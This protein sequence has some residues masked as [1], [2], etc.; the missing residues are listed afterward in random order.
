MHYPFWDTSVSYGLMMA[1]IAIVHVFISHFAIGGGFYLVITETIA[2]NRNDTHQLDYLKKISKF[3]ILTTLVMG[4]LTGVAI[5]TIIGLI[6][7]S[8]TEVLIHNF[9][10]GW[11]IEW[12]F[13]VVEIAA[14]LMYYYGWER[15]TAKA[16]I[17]LGWIYFIF[18]WLS[19]VVINGIVAFMLTP[20]QWLETGDFWDGFF[21]PTYWPSLVFRTGI[22][23]LLAGL[24]TM[25]YVSKI[26]DANSKKITVRYNAIWGLIGAAIVL[27]SLVWYEAAIPATFMETAREIMSFPFEIMG[28]IN[29]F[30]W[31]IV[32]L[33]LI[34]GFLIPKRMH[35]TVAVLLMALGFCYFGSFEWWRESLRKPFVIVDYMYGNRVA[36][37]TVSETAAAGFLPGVEYRT[38]DDGADLFRQQCRTCHTISGYKAL[39]PHYD[40]TDIDFIAGTIIGQHTMIGNMPPFSGTPQEA[41]LIAAHLYQFTDH[42]HISEIYNLSGQS[43]GEKV[44][45]IRCGKCHVIGGYSDKTESLVNLDDGE[46]ND[47]L[48]IIGELTDEMPAFTGDSTERAAL[49]EYFK[50]LSKGDPHAPGI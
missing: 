22:S 44:Y 43:L 50:T 48:D 28:M 30:L 20:G 46:Y 18:A 37:N 6:N 38:G 45:E 47:L 24:F 4:A 27:P 3:F 21:N 16:H 39:K 42:R 14:A 9:V 12:T 13:F 5:W 17:T 1:I 41:Q 36:V 25:L 29:W 49:I 34:F 8:A 40:G 35:F 7:P 2:R 31:P 19:L 15:L 11:A 33:L 23:I 10:W 32:A 26:P